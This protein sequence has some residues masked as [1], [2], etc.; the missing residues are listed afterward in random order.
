MLA[1][2][3]SEFSRDQLLLEGTEFMKV[4]PSAPCTGSQ[5]DDAERSGGVSKGK[6]HAIAT[7]GKLPDKFNIERPNQ[8]Q[9]LSRHLITH[10]D[11][12]VVENI[13]LQ[14]VHQRHMVVKPPP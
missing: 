5:C 12:V 1:E 7:G 2:D 14:Q 6:I 8:V 13:K 9:L 10:E 11:G 3:R 4:E